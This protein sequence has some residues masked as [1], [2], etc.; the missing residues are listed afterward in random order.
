M[1]EKTAPRSI[2]Q[3]LAALRAAL[4]GED[5]ALVQDALYDAEGLASGTYT[6]VNDAAANARNTNVLRYTPGTTVEIYSASSGAI[7]LPTATDLIAVFANVRHSTTTDFSFRIRIDSDIYNQ[8]TPP[9]KIIHQ[10]A[11][12]PRWYF[13]GFVAKKNAIVDMYVASIASAASS[14]FDIDTIVLA[15]A[16]LVHIIGL[17]GA[18][19]TE[20]NSLIALATLDVNHARLTLPQPTA[21][22]GTRPI[23]HDEL[24]FYTKAQALYPLLLE[25]GGLNESVGNKWRQHA[26][27]D[28]VQLNTWTVYRRTAYLI[29]Q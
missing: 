16:R 21:L 7:T 23:Q 10:A 5:P 19:E 12:W 4:A 25:T 24:I 11:V 17:P 2:E 6:S 3:Y 22:A 20:L 8:F 28:G 15:D 9:V 1:N 26:T 13:C 14:F 27:A 29:P 18:S